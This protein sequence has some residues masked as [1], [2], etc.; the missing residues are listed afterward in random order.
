MKRRSALIVV[1]LFFIIFLT[2]CQSVS[3][4]YS[5][6]NSD[7]TID[8][9]FPR[10]MSIRAEQEYMAI[11]KGGKASDFL[12][13]NSYNYDV[14]EEDMLF[15]ARSCALA[16][17]YENEYK[18]LECL[19][20]KIDGDKI[21]K[22][23]NYSKSKVLIM[24]GKLASALQLL[25]KDLEFADSQKIADEIQSI[26][27][28]GDEGPAGGYIFYDKGSYSDGWRYLEAAPQDLDDTYAFGGIGLHIVGTSAAVGQG[29]AN[30]ELLIKE[31]DGN[32]PNGI[33]YSVYRKDEKS[34]IPTGICSAAKACA[35]YKFNG[36]DDWFLPSKDELNLMYVNLHENGLGNF[37]TWFHP[38]LSS[39]AS[40]EDDWHLWC[41]NFVYGLQGLEG[42]LYG[43]YVRPVR[44]F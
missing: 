28:I 31:I 32:S 39:T 6:N 7:R 19:G 41:Q 40:A 14:T 21:S 37:G 12:A 35:D 4:L 43:D 17:G 33:D 34:F 20:Y 44:A 36:Y 15:Y 30:T 24:E 22:A 26:L 38:Y 8:V 1:I 2:A 25:N 18:M 10:N 42:R 29:K 23:E 11:I 13:F 5:E 3:K 27:V 9:D 16:G